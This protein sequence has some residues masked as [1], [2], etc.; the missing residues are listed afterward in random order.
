[1]HYK[2]EIFPENIPRQSYGCGCCGC[3]CR[4]TVG[5]VGPIGP[6]GPVGPA[7]TSATASYALFAN[8]STE[9]SIIET[10]VPFPTALSNTSSVTA[11]ENGTIFT[12]SGGTS[13]HTYL[14]QFSVTAIPANTDTNS[15]LTLSIN[16][17]LTAASKALVTQANG[18]NAYGK[19]SGR[20]IIEVPANSSTTVSVQAD[21]N[22]FTLLSPSVGTTIS[23]IELV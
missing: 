12:L 2:N 13:G 4:G 5:P 14:V 1:M 10:A 11:N 21:G 22:T 7:G 8:T 20:Y 18:T 3:C 23:F 19:A 6:V 17:V 9:G 16:S 15:Y